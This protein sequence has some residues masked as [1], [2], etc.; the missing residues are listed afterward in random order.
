MRCLGEER[1]PGGD[2]C[3]HCPGEERALP[4]EKRMP[5]NSLR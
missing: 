2:A 3:T 1:S 5:I 4:R